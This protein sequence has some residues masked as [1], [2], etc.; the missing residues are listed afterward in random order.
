MYEY[1]MKKRYKKRHI[2]D[3]INKIR[4]LNRLKRYTFFKPLLINILLQKFLHEYILYL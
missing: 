3:I 4:F 2:N 1:I